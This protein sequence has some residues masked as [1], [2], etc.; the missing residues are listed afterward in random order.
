[1]ETFTK[2]S[3][4]VYLT[5]FAFKGVKKIHG[6]WDERTRDLERSKLEGPKS[7]PLG[8]PKWVIL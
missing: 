5:F 3:V 1:M 6:R 8:Q 7:T 2:S 4:Y